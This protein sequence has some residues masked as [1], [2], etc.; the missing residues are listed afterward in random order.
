MLIDAFVQRLNLFLSQ[1][2]LPSEC[3]L[4]YFIH[5]VSLVKDLL[6]PFEVIPSYKCPVYHPSF[7]LRI[8]IYH[9]NKLCNWAHQNHDALTAIFSGAVLLFIACLVFKS[10]GNIHKGVEITKPGTFWKLSN[11]E[12]TSL[13]DDVHFVLDWEIDVLHGL[14]C[15]DDCG[16]WFI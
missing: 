16:T 14:A 5:F 10:G 12:Y 7:A 11:D 3:T 1:F 4:P 8:F 2:S 15:F 13:I 6:Y 9:W